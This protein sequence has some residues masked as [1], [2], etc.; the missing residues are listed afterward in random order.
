M[1]THC[2]C[3]TGANKCEP[4]DYVRRVTPR[5][6]EATVPTRDPGLQWLHDGSISAPKSSFLE[7]SR[8]KKMALPKTRF[9]RVTRDRATE[10]FL[11]A[12]TPRVS[13]ALRGVCPRLGGHG[14]SGT[15][16]SLLAESPALWC[17]Q[18]PLHKLLLLHKQNYLGE[19]LLSLHLKNCVTWLWKSVRL[20]SSTVGG[21][22]DWT[23][24]TGR[25]FSSVLLRP[26]VKALILIFSIILCD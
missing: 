22:S 23:P 19:N 5:A 21:P 8:I 12:S 25:L 17:G 16:A 24:R 15:Q 11:L 26:A 20:T 14:T 1:S 6:V 3:P 9:S 10:A 18:I 13:R 7:G 4:K 2:W